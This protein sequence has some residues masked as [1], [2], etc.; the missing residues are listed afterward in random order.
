VK[1]GPSPFLTPI[2]VYKKVA[3]RLPALSGE[4]GARIGQ[5]TARLPCG[6]LGFHPYYQLL[7][8]G[9]ASAAGASAR[10]ATA[11]AGARRFTAVAATMVTSLGQTRQRSSHNRSGQNHN[12][13]KLH[14]QIL[15]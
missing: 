3:P 11:A 5:K 9:I 6:P 12:F 7:S 1:N 13:H 8:G 2:Y 15:H 14:D 4:R 10:T